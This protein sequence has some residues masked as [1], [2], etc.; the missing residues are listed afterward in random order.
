MG[1]GM[2]CEA[3]RIVIDVEHRFF[4]QCRRLR[5][6]AHGPRNRFR[7]V[8]GGPEPWQQAY[9]RERGEL[10]NRGYNGSIGWVWDRDET[11]PLIV[12]PN[13]KSCDQDVQSGRSQ[14]AGEIPGG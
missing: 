3:L 9:V 10:R 6:V 7:L 2:R 1:N 4:D 8:H 12:S 5:S 14:S 11:P 13:A